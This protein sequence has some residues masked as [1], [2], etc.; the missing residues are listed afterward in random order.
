MCGCPQHAAYNARVNGAII[1]HTRLY[2]AACEAMRCICWRL[3]RVP[4]PTSSAANR[5]FLVFRRE[6]RT[7]RVRMLIVYPMK[8]RQPSLSASVFLSEMAPSPKSPSISALVLAWSPV[9]WSCKHTPA[10]SSTYIMQRPARRW[11]LFGPSFRLS[12]PAEGR[13]ARTELAAPKSVLLEQLGRPYEK[14]TGKPW[15]PD[16]TTV[17]KTYMSYRISWLGRQRRM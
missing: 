13:K 17:A 9:S 4:S 2:R 15:T 8:S 6:I 7:R 16:L 5:A 12:N 10:T 14:L 3:T 1:G 11:S